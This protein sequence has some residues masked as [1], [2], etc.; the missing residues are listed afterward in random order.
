MERSNSQAAGGVLPIW[1][2]LVVPKVQV[3]SLLSVRLQ[4][5]FVNSIN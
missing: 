4:E 3:E 1:A 2:L 5:P